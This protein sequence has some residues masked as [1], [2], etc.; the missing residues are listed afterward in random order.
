MIEGVLLVDDTGL[1]KFSYLDPAIDPTIF[2]GFISAIKSLMDSLFHQQLKKIEAGDIFLYHERVEDLPYSLIIIGHHEDNNPT[3][4]K[5]ATKL[6]EYFAKK[7]REMPSMSLEVEQLN[8]PEFQHE[9]FKLLEQ[10]RN[11]MIRTFLLKVFHDPAYS[12]LLENF[13]MIIEGVLLGYEIEAKEAPPEFEK[14]LSAIR[15]IFVTRSIATRVP[16]KKTGK[17]IVIDVDKREIRGPK[18]TSFG[19][20][21]KELIRKGKFEEAITMINLTFKVAYRFGF[22]FTEK[23]SLEL[24]IKELKT[25]IKRHKDGV[26]IV[27]FATKVAQLLFD[28]PDSKLKDIENKLRLGIFLT[29]L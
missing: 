18:G 9:I 13:D 19:K 14:I 6:A 15:E 12:W 24:I 26:I 1:P 25:Q 20:K 3:L 17:K 28:I 29:A 23:A 8:D 5:Y 4:E 7:I 21:I 10:Y 16:L 2:S 11:E 27:N 22:I